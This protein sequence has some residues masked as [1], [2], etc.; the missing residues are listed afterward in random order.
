MLQMFE[1]GMKN[2]DWWNSI[3]PTY[4]RNVV[5]RLSL[6]ILVQ[7]PAIETC[8]MSIDEIVRIFSKS[9]SLYRGGEFGIFQ[10]PIEAYKEARNSSKSQDLE[11][12]VIFPSPPDIFSKGHFPECNVIGRG[13]RNTSWGGRR[14]KRHK[15]CQFL[16]DCEI[17]VH[18]KMLWY[19]KTVG[20]L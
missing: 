17:R 14:E 9:Q 2:V 12:L 15:T 3:T 7:V 13:S 5:E 6:I 4:S 8:F 11:K 18:S 16:N 10:V 1:F 20:I 19:T